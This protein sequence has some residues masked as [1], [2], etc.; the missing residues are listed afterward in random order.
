MDFW[1]DNNTFITKKKWKMW[2]QKNV[3]VVS[4]LKLKN[5]TSS[6]K[7]FTNEVH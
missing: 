7:E 3:K 1:N 4:K 6:K 5:K 2:T